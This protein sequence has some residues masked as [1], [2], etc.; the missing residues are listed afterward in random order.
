MRDI[1]LVD[2]ELSDDR[3][4]IGLQGIS[5]LIGVLRIAPPC[6]MGINVDFGAFGEG[7]DAIIL[8]AFVDRI[9]P[10]RQLF[11]NF[12]GLQP[13]VLQ[14]HRHGTSEALFAYLASRPVQ[15][16]P[17]TTAV[18]G[19]AQIQAVAVGMA[20]DIFQGR[21]RTCRQPMDLT[22]QLLCPNTCPN[23]YTAIGR[24]IKES[25]ETLSELIH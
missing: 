19:N 24:L 17:T 2:R 14:R 1:D 9:E 20:T 13:R 7:H 6:S 8:A 4:S 10:R 5:P 23:N 15:E 21:Y 11:A 22:S 25:P 16:N 18:I 12:V 3:I